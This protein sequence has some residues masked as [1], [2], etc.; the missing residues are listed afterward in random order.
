ME[1]PF[2]LQTV[3]VGGKEPKLAVKT[4]VEKKKKKKK[5]QTSVVVVDVV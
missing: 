1:E 2:Q 3:T 4:S 5:K